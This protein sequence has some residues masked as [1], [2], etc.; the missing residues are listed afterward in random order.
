MAAAGGHGANDAARSSHASKKLQLRQI[1]H[2]LRI[3][4]PGDS[5]GGRGR[6]SAGGPGLDRGP[7]PSPSPSPAANE[8]QSMPAGHHLGG[9]IGRHM[10]DGL[11]KVPDRM[12]GGRRDGERVVRARVRAQGQRR[13]APLGWGNEWTV[14]GDAE[15]AWFLPMWQFSPVLGPWLGGCSR[16]DPDPD[17]G[18]RLRL[19]SHAMPHSSRGCGVA[20]NVTLGCCTA[21]KHGSPPASRC[22]SNARFLSQSRSRARTEISGR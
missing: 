3:E 9:E 11:R 7:A 2:L 8:R 6:D 21:S 17:P 10:C 4:I 20:Q 13:T 18:T 19:S 14:V 12:G 5:G 1:G 22:I 16:C 15:L